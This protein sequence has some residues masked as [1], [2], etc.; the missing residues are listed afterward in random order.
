M[1]F[2]LFILIYFNYF[3]NMLIGTLSLLLIS[4][5]TEKVS[6]SLI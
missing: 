2:Y 3:F 4:N 1:F 6:F 5:Q